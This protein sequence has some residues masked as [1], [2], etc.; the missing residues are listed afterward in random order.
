MKLFKNDIPH[1]KRVAKIAFKLG[2]SENIVEETLN[3]MYSYIRNKFENVQIPDED[4]LMS[5][6]EFNKVFPVINIPK[7]GWFRPSYGK[8]KHTMQ[9]KL[10]KKSNGKNK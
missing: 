4:V 9:S 6:E 8:Y 2:L 7:L 1:D 10:N 5:E 3:I